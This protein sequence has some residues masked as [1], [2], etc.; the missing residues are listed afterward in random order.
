MYHEVDRCVKTDPAF[1]LFFVLATGINTLKLSGT[2]GVGFAIPIDMAWQVSYVRVV[3]VVTSRVLPRKVVGSLAAWVG[4]SVTFSVLL[5]LSLLL[6]LC[7]R[8]IT[9]VRSL[10]CC[11]YF[12]CFA[13][14]LSRSAI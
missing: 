14:T 12:S 11:G 13:E 7:L 10:A 3:L 5:F 9:C 2:E 6:K 4:C 1:T 8:A